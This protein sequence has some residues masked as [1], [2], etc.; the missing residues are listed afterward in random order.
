MQELIVFANDLLDTA[1]GISVG[2]E[3]SQ[4]CDPNFVRRCV[5]ERA[6][7]LC[8]TSPM[9]AT[10]KSF[11]PALPLTDRACVQQRLRRMFVGAVAAVDN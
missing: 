3:H 4:T 8:A 11:K 6:T 5:F 9:I 2:A 1:A 10:F 7:R